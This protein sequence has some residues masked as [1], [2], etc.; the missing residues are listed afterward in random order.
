MKQADKVEEKIYDM[1]GRL[2]LSRE[3][4][5]SSGLHAINIYNTD[6]TGQGVYLYQLEMRGIKVCKQFVLL[7]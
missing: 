7:E 3:H 6:L 4:K 5:L 1:T 2:L